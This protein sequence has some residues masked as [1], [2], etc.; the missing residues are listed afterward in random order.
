MPKRRSK[1]RPTVAVPLPW[2]TVTGTMISEADLLQEL[3][4]L[5]LEGSLYFLIRLLQHEDSPGPG[6]RP[7]L[8][9]L[10]PQLF[11]NELGRR[12]YAHL[13]SS[14]HW[15]FFSKWQLLLAIKLLSTFGSRDEV[16]QQPDPK[17]LLRILLM[18]NGLY[19]DDAGPQTVGASDV[20][21]VQSVALRGYALPQYERPT[22]LIS[23]YAEI[24]DNLASSDNE[25]QFNAWVDVRQVILDTLGFEL[26]VFKAVLFAVLANATPVHDDAEDSFR[27]GNFDPD[28]Y[29]APS[30]MPT[31]MIK[32]VL[33]HITIAPDQIR[34]MHLS[35]YK[36]TIGNPVDIEILLR[37]P[38]IQLPNGLLAGLSGEL[39]VQR[40]TSGLYWD[41]E[42]AL[43]DGPGDRPNRSAFRTFFGELHERYGQS[44]LRRIVDRQTKAKKKARLFYDTDYGTGRGSKPD[45]VLIETV[46]AKNTRVTF[47]EF[48]VGRPRY[49]Q[50]IVRGDVEAFNQD[51]ET[52]IQDGLNQEISLF[53]Q[54]A[55]EQRTL[56]DV[57]TE[58]ITA[59]FF[60]VVVTDPYPAMEMFLDSLRQKL[61]ALNRRI[62]AV[63]STARSF[64]AFRNWNSWKHCLISAF[65]TCC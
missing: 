8:D 33:D 29:F 9:S 6:Q 7:N 23:R 27:P 32:T 54:I 10:I 56:A 26:G 15:I 25:K 62:P 2:T 58:N 59:W 18:I 41:I 36:E 61:T 12:T 30:P 37:K 35:T 51:L 43:P 65:P 53:S 16:A 20:E 11:K 46:G 57:T 44:V 40:Y 45:N 38:L 21:Q 47:F 1:L 64:C 60:V 31:G 55:Y 34:D 17:Y 63:V 49:R 5:P 19:P 24:Y 28:A 52:K 48:K 42:A 22:N 39:L 14:G 4:R 3:R 50:S 13:R